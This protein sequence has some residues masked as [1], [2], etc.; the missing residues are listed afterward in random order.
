MIRLRTWTLTI[1]FIL[2]SRH[3][4]I[5]SLAVRLGTEAWG[6]GLLGT[7]GTLKYVRRICQVD[8]SL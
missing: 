3:C 8:G 5:I 7:A 2:G 4:S 1:S 6:E